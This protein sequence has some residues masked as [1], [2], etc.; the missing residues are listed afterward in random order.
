[1]TDVSL[2]EFFS[3]NKKIEASTLYDDELLEKCF[4]NKFDTS[5]ELLIV[6]KKQLKTPNALDGQS[7][8]SLITKRFGSSLVLHDFEQLIDKKYCETRQSHETN[9][10]GGNNLSTSEEVQSS[11]NHS[12]NME[13]LKILPFHPFIWILTPSLMKIFVVGIVEKVVK[14]RAENFWNMISQNID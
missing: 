7:G 6:H 8:M 12:T 1:M 5:D 14:K 2:I 4:L 10:P 3:A 13:L 11:L 9:C